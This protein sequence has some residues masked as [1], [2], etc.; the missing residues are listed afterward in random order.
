[1]SAWSSE[2]SEVTETVLAFSEANL[3]AARAQPALVEEWH[4]LEQQIFSGGYEGRAIH[5]MVQNGADEILTWAKD[6]TERDFVCDQIRV[7]LTPN[8]LYCAN[9]GAPVRVR[10]VQAMLGAARSDKSSDLIGTFGVGFKSVLQLTDRPEFYST[11][12]SFVFSQRN[13]EQQFREVVEDSGDSPFKFPTLRT[14]TPADFEEAADKDA[15]LRELAEWKASTI[16]KLPLLKT[17]AADLRDIVKEFSSSFLLFSPHV[18]SL[19]LE[20]RIGAGGSREIETKLENSSNG[21]ISPGK[22]EDKW[23]ATIVLKEGEKSDRWMVSTSF[24]TPTAVSR[25]D[26]G[27]LAPQDPEEKWRVPI[28]WAVP[29]NVGRQRGEFWAFFSTDSETTLSGIL[30]APWKTNVD[31]TYIHKAGIEALDTEGN[32]LNGQLVHAAAALVIDSI[33]LLQ[34][35]WPDDCCR[36][37]IALP[38]RF[39]GAEVLNWAD[40]LLGRRIY[41]V[42]KESKSLPDQTG[43]LQM[44][45]SLHLHPDVVDEAVDEWVKFENRPARWVHPHVQ[46]EG[47]EKKAK[48]RRLMSPETADGQQLPQKR[49]SEIKDWLTALVHEK[50]PDSSLAALRVAAVL[51]ETTMPEREHEAV[52]KSEILLSE[53]GGLVPVKPG[54]IFLPGSQPAQDGVHYVHNELAEEQNRELFRRLGIEELSSANELR[55]LV[56]DGFSD[57]TQW[58]IFW[59][60]VRRS[61]EGEVFELLQPSIESDQ[62]VRVRTS[63]GVWKRLFEVFR[64]GVIVTADRDPA[65]TLDEEWHAD[66]LSLLE[67]LGLVDKPRDGA[68]HETETWFGKYRAEA[69]TA[70]MKTVERRVGGGAPDLDLVQ[71]NQRQ[72]F[73]PLDPLKSLSHEAKAELT[74][75][76]LPYA[77]NDSSTWTLAHTTVGR[78]PTHDHEA[79]LPWWLKREGCLHTSLGIRPIADCVGPQ[80]SSLKEVFPVV[81]LG[82]DQADLL[83]LPATE[84]DFA[85]RIWDKALGRADQLAG[86]AL[87]ALYSSAADNGRPAPEHLHCHVGVGSLQ[88]TPREQ[89]TIVTEDSKFETLLKERRPCLIGT[90]E[91]AEILAALW[92]LSRSEVE[93]LIEYEQARPELL[94]VDEF[95]VLRTHLDARSAQLLLVPCSMLERVLVTDSGSQSEPKEVLLENGR[96]YWDEEVDR[97]NLLRYLD[98]E[99]TLELG[100]EVIQEILGQEARPNHRAQV[101]RVRQKRNFETKLLEAIPVDVIRHSIPEKVL[102]A[103]ADDEDVDENN[104]ET[105]VQLAKAV[106]GTGLLK[107]LR[108]DFEERGFEPPRQFGGGRVARRWVEELGFA[109]E[110]AGFEKANRERLIEIEGPPDLPALHDYQESV[111]ENF[112]DLLKGPTGARGLLCLPTGAGKTRVAVQ[113][114]V[115]LIRDG[116]LDG[117][118]LW[119]AQTDELCEQAVQTWSEIWRAKGSSDRLAISRLW[120]TNEVPE[121]PDLCQVVVATIDKLDKLDGLEPGDRND[122]YGWLAKATCVVIDEAHRA[123]AN[124]KSYNRLLKWLGLDHNKKARNLIG[125]TATPYR[126]TSEEETRRLIRRFA[127]KRIDE[128]VFDE[129]AYSELQR[130]GHLAKVQ[131]K[132]LKGRDLQLRP[133]ELVYLKKFRRLHPAAAKRIGDDKV[134]NKAIIKSIVSLDENWPVLVFATSVSHAQALAAMLIMKG[135]S[136]AAIHSGTSAGERRHQ[137]QQFKSGGIRV[138][139]NYAVLTEGFDAPKIRALYITRPTYSPNL[140]Q[141]MIGRGLRGPLN[142]GEEECLIFDVEDNIAMYEEQMAFH[143]FEPLWLNS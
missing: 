33:P 46:S 77:A 105:I 135:V 100:E 49:L 19:R 29:E 62:P 10:G 32:T 117:P 65:T 8:V 45:T 132:I 83:G 90:T 6:S 134:R 70:F 41:E 110:Y 18:G 30:N 106:Y 7:I 133:E 99:L 96:V 107:R 130:S 12:G 25:A 125:L 113:S 102:Q 143:E 27:P 142:G 31:R 103:A 51:L 108:R 20:D 17:K 9:H 98:D 67:R 75:F 3:N 72:K 4:G 15:I 131:H 86:K 35:F 26:A 28:T 136:A 21:K 104:P 14:A 121:T 115:E 38:G 116:K 118:I 54:D 95:P 124:T 59:R 34:K 66:D 97:E 44:P 94:L 74:K 128:G 23:N 42:G 120:S 88:K 47:R 141:Q 40:R 63:S 92:G 111:K 137:I 61:D 53:S 39:T 52:R 119:V 22:N 50:T 13:A 139:T 78:W 71:F 140:Y 1:M 114:M 5:E 91:Q 123:G 60:L 112:Q 89:V 48:A 79:P 36:F 2:E 126:G 37:L 73:G 84:G 76:V 58:S 122:P 87:G 68:G 127:N 93:W 56:D 80:M 55:Q 81:G 109:R 82:T 24:C 57:R 85:D 64:E 129:D 43:A 69:L 138:L 11:T 16:V 101:R